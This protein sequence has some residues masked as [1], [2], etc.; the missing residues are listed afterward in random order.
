MDISGLEWAFNPV[1]LMSLCE[2]MYT[3]TLKQMG[4]Y[5]VAMEVKIGGMHLQA[6]EHQG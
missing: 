3:E 5:H 6:A 4:E 1:W 2:E